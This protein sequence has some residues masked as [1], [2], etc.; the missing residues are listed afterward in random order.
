VEAFLRENPKFVVDRD[1]EEKMAFTF[2]PA[3][4]L[5]RVG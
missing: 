4:W 1:R 3:G 2:A 5:R